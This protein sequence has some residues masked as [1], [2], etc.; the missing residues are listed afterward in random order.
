MTVQLPINR[1]KPLLSLRSPFQGVTKPPDFDVEFN[2]LCR[3]LEGVQK[4]CLFLEKAKSPAAEI[5]GGH[6]TLSTLS[7]RQ[8]SVHLNLGAKTPKRP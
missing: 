3:G 6:R 1:L 7:H 5:E 2:E 4:V 8:N